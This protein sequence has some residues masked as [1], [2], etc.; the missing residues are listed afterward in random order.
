[1]TEHDLER[2]ASPQ[3]LRLHRAMVA[4]AWRCVPRSFGRHDG[5]H[6]SDLRDHP[7]QQTGSPAS[8]GGVWLLIARGLTC[9]NDPRSHTDGPHD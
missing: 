2:E 4:A 8:E 9:L 7:D 6:P 1:M 5:R 3:P